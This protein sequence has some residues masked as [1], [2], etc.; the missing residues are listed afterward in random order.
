MRASS[1]ARSASRPRSA[2][3][4]ARSRAPSASAAATTATMR[5][6]ASATQF[7]ASATVKRPVGAMWNQLKAAALASEVP[8]PSHAP[9]TI[10][11]SKTGTR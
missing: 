9:H 10:E 7:S 11:T 5:K 3:S 1:A 2:A 4:R 8:M 6:T